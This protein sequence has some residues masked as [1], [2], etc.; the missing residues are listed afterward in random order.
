[1]ECVTGRR[2]LT[3][4]PFCRLFF[5]VIRQLWTTMEPQLTQVVD[6]LYIVDVIK[7]LMKNVFVYSPETVFAVKDS[8]LV[9]T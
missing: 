9:L 8:K 4:F 3:A 5:I 2:A 6:I 7:T 1:M